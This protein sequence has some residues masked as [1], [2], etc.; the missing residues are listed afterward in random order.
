MAQVDNANG[1]D[2]IPLARLPRR[3]KQTSC[4]TVL[5]NVLATPHNIRYAHQNVPA[6]QRL[7]DRECLEARVMGFDKSQAL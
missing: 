5:I 4:T 1:K 7:A 3:K 2:E 6:Q